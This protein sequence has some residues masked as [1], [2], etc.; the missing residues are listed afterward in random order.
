MNSNCNPVISLEQVLRDIAPKGLNGPLPPVELWNPSQC[1]DIDMEIRAD[2]SWWHEGRRIERERLVKLFSRILRKD[3]DGQ[4]YLVTPYEKVIV[5][6]SDAPFIAIR[7]D[8]LGEPGPDQELAFTTNLGELVLA[9]PDRPLR[10]LVDP[11]TQQPSPY[12]G[13]RGRLDAR[14]T[15]PTYYDLAEMAEPAPEAPETYGVWSKGVFFPVGS[16]VA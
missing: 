16:L 14:L 12:I 1:S 7:V 9:G 15:R 4:T 2:G 10:I 6:V 11:Q 13:V 3:P 5:H 8:R